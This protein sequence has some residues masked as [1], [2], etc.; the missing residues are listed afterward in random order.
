M[1][2][3]MKEMIAQAA[4]RLVMEQNRKKLTVKDI[5]EECRI[6]RQAFYYHFEDI[7]ALFR[8][9]MEK[10][11]KRLLEELREHQDT[12]R[13]IKEFFLLAIT[14]RPYVKKGMETNY[15]EEFERLLSQC[16]YALFEQVVETENLYQGYSRAEIKVFLRYHSRALFGILQE[17]SEEDDAD[18][19]RIVHCVY[20]L[21]AGKVSPGL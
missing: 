7:P 13:R 11:M 16:A 5:V 21:L 4:K 19:D 8:W 14:A 10:D 9:M 6:T 20:L 1:P 3:D 2:I 18:I 17:W 15:G 12:E